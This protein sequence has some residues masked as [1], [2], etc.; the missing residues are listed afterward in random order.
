MGHNPLSKTAERLQHNLK[1]F[2]G[3]RLEVYRDGRTTFVRKSAQTVAHNSK[4][5]AE[6]QKLVRLAEIGEACNLFHVPTVLNH[7][8]NEDG[9]EYYDSEFISSWE[10]GSHLSALDA[11][12]INQLAQRIG[13][14]I[15]VFASTAVEREK[16]IDE[17]EF[18]R[19]KLRETSDSLSKITDVDQYLSVLILEYNALIERI[20][21]PSDFPK[22]VATFCH[23]DLALD[24][25]LID[26]D[27]RLYL[28]DPL[29]NDYESYLWDVSK[30]FQSSL[31]YWQ[32]IKQGEFEFDWK[33]QKIHLHV[34][35]RISIFNNEYAQIINRRYHSG[36]ALIYL[37]TS[38]SRVVKYWKTRSQLG[39]L[40]ALTNALL[41]RYQQG[42]YVLNEPL[43]P[44]RR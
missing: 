20:D 23:G 9:T 41:T 11:L 17:H 24:N 7:D 14:V 37:A 33:T 13:D 29:I 35:E 26:Q 4:L 1:G 3:Y 38:L 22:Q 15:N 10:L 19:T 44:L 31:T 36:M 25:I 34:S 39:A 18:I 21:F 32:Q 27:Q 2:S 8:V 12:Q 43:S 5:R 6:I 16:S 42:A 28:I 40:L 30:V